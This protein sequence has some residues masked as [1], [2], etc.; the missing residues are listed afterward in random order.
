VEKT[1]D[2]MNVAAPP[3]GGARDPEFWSGNNAYRGIIGVL[4]FP[5]IKG[6]EP[7]MVV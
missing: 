6:H 3:A 2:E 7:I 1:P 4:K 5:L